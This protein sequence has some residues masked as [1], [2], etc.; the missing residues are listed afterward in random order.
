[1]LQ[2]SPRERVQSDPELAEP[3]AKRRRLV[4]SVE[5]QGVLQQ[6]QQ[7]LNSLEA[8]VEEEDDGEESDTIPFA[9]D[10]Y[11]SIMD[12]N[13]NL[14]LI[15][16]VHPDPDFDNIE[17]RNEKG[18]IVHNRAA[19]VGSSDAIATLKSSGVGPW[20]VVPQ[21]IG[22]SSGENSIHEALCD[23]GIELKVT[24]SESDEFN[25]N[26]GSDSDDVDGAHPDDPH[27]LRAD[28]TPSRNPNG[29]S[30]SSSPDLAR[31][32]RIQGSPVKSYYK[33][34]PLDD[35]GATDTETPRSFAD[36]ASA[37]HGGAYLSAFK[38]DQKESAAN[39]LTDSLIVQVAGGDISA[40][41]DI[42]DVLSLLDDDAFDQNRSSQ[43]EKTMEKI[44]NSSQGTK[45]REFRSG[46]NSI[47]RSSSRT[48]GRDSA[49]VDDDKHSCDAGSEQSD[50]EEKTPDR[51]NESADVPFTST[52][53]GSNCSLKRRLRAVRPRADRPHSLTG[54]FKLPLID[55]D[56]S[57]CASE[58]EVSVHSTW[59]NVEC[60]PLMSQSLCAP[61]RHRGTAAGRRKLRARRMPRSMSDGEHLGMWL[62]A[63]SSFHT[64]AASE[65]PVNDGDELSTKVV[66]EEDPLTERMEADG[67]SAEEVTGAEQSDAAPAW[68]WD[69]YN[70]PAHNEDGDGEQRLDDSRLT[71][72]GDDYRLHMRAMTGSPRQSPI[73][74][75]SRDTSDSE[76][77][78]DLRELLNE[79][80]ASFR[81]ACDAFDGQRR[82]VQNGH[83]LADLTATCET[84]IRCLQA[85]TKSALCS[86][87]ARCPQEDYSRITSQLKEWQDLLFA[88]KSLSMKKAKQVR[89]PAPADANG[90]T[91][92]LVHGEMARLAQSLKQ[93]IEESALNRSF[94]STV[95]CLRSLDDVVDTQELFQDLH[96]R[97]QAERKRLRMLL[98]TYEMATDVTDDEIK[99]ELEQLCHYCDGALE[100]CAHQISELGRLKQQWIDWC[101]TKEMMERLLGSLERKMTNLEL[102]KS[103]PEMVDDKPDVKVVY[104]ELELCQDRMNRLE[105]M[106]NYLVSSCDQTPSTSSSSAGVTPDFRTELTACGEALSDLRERFKDLP[107]GW[108]L[109]SKEATLAR[110]KSNDHTTTRRKS[111]D[112]S[113]ARR[114]SDDSTT[115]RKRSKPR[116]R[117]QLATNRG[118]L[119]VAWDCVSASRP[120]QLCLVLLLLVGGLMQFWPGDNEPVNNWRNAWGPQLNYVRGPPPS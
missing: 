58:M 111:D 92:A 102:S 107:D 95:G 84:N 93:L 78:T 89:R 2:Q 5:R 72:F 82:G 118:V 34:V 55:L 91:T 76:P 45:W 57:A 44:R 19:M 104:S 11:E 16:D 15:G 42:E 4:P 86:P 25:N 110:R 61:G 9:A 97:L 32:K 114:K 70:P 96:S 7:R 29:Q 103:H 116:Q 31:R 65:A 33:T 30:G 54:G 115:R 108:T 41:N 18:Q 20:E 120:I 63:Q 53:V 59:S 56:A 109:C 74:V 112:H 119:R 3:S 17:Y 49:T 79:S 46:T 67:G 68:E 13:G 60:T 35:T 48:L 22:Y 88:V 8:E 1:M 80:T 98:K 117:Q 38:Y 52:P 66:E 101:E 51:P 28:R 24:R 87:K 39:T 69:D 14:D 71:D 37:T 40:Q 73:G 43:F 99:S 94:T 100:S 85:I 81:K 10:E 6:L 113:S 62:N 83:G 27:R 105:T 106:C 64:P 90:E 26:N 77:A 75:S 23:V 47:G 36:N 21:D 12:D 50:V